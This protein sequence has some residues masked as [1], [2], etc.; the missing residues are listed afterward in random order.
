M[1]KK[2]T[3]SCTEL[4]VSFHSFLA[5]YLSLFLSLYTFLYMNR[6]LSLCVLISFRF[7]MDMSFSIPVY[8]Y[9]YDLHF[10]SSY[11]SL[12]LLGVVSSVF[13]YSF[14]PMWQKN[15]IE[16]KKRFS[17]FV[18]YI[19]S[20]VHVPVFFSIS[21]ESEPRGWYASVFVAHTPFFFFFSLLDCFACPWGGV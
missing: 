8:F 11:F 20:V 13:M 6:Y 9:T 17:A 15:D 7:P 12:L 4:T 21:T 16:K 10:A 19:F 3:L 2:Q 18:S 1:E 5:L 14:D